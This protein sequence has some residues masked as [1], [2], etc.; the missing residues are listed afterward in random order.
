[1][2]IRI[3]KISRT[4]AGDYLVNVTLVN[5]QGESGVLRYVHLPEA[6]TRNAVAFQGALR[7]AVATAVA[8]RIA[9]R[10]QAIPVPIRALEGQDIS[11]N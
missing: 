5:V 9:G 6:A 11:E 7:S 4:K 2:P 3:D 8:A 10:A 1:M